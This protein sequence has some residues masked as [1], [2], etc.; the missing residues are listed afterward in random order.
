MKIRHFS[1][2]VFLL[3]NVIITFGQ[4][5]KISEQEIVTLRKSVLKNAKLHNTIVSEFVQLKHFEFLSND[6]KSTGVLYYKSPD[7]IKWQY[8]E[9]FNYSATFKGAVLYIND[10]GKKSD[11]DLSSNK[12]F[13]SLKKLWR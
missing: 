4:K 2:V 9:P 6:I 7:F 1:I 5:T 12:V 13:K 8:Q 11:I 3:L 10:D